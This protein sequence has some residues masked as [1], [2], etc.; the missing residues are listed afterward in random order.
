M[1]VLVTIVVH[2]AKHFMF[3]CDNYYLSL[4]KFCIDNLSDDFIIVV[5]GD[6]QDL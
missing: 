3:A 4:N 1:T 5:P 2:T 6:L